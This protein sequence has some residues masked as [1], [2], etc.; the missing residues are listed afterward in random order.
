MQKAKDECVKITA[1]LFRVS[2]DEDDDVNNNND[3]DD[4][5]DNKE[6]EDK[7][8]STRETVSRS[9]PSKETESRS[10]GA[11]KGKVSSNSEAPSSLAKPDP[12]LS[13]STLYIGSCTL[14]LS[15]PSASFIPISRTSSSLNN[16]EEH[17]TS[18]TKK[19]HDK[20][21]NNELVVTPTIGTRRLTVPVAD[22]DRIFSALKRD[23]SFTREPSTSLHSSSSE[24]RP[25]CTD[26]SSIA[27][28][29]S[30]CSRLSPNFLEVPPE[31]SEFHG[32][33]CPCDSCKTPTISGN[34]IVDEE[35]PNAASRDSAVVQDISD[36]RSSKSDARRLTLPMTSADLSR[37]T[38]QEEPAKKLPTFEDIVA[39]TSVNPIRKF[40]IA[41]AAICSSLAPS[42]LGAIPGVPSNLLPNGNGREGDLS[43]SGTFSN[44]S[45]SSTVASDDA[46]TGRTGRKL[47]QF[48]RLHIPEQL[49][50]ATWRGHEDCHHLHHHHHHH[51]VF[52]HIHVP[53]ITFTA[54]ATDGTG[55]KFNFAIRRHSQA[56][57]WRRTHVVSSFSL[58]F[59]FFVNIALWNKGEEGESSSGQVEP[60]QLE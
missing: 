12:E 39:G 32:R 28:S 38:R 54:P 4:D 55:R 52:P 37:S 3:N 19:K 41:S 58:V 29:Q 31:T 13:V 30:R 2:F 17:A 26:A 50:G 49:P 6:K 36:E 11:E 5:D 33:C 1:A 14:E 22:S 46:T 56:V 7:A 27:T 57:S 16:V 40:S 51:H 47:R 20:V 53:T 44:L 43:R 59:L 60:S 24:D 8:S 15:R 45:T 23:R 25:A 48:L 34:S 18:D 35:V 10:S 21:D 42:L 9:S